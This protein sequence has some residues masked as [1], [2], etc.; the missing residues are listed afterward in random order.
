MGVADTLMPKGHLSLK[1][2]ADAHA[3][4]LLSHKSITMSLT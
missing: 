2:H 4:N 1:R 3:S